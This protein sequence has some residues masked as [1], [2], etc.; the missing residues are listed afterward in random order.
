MSTRPFNIFEFGA[1]SGNDAEY[2][3]K[4]IN[5]KTS[6]FHYTGVEHPDSFPNSKIEI[7]QRLLAQG[8]SESKFEIKPQLFEEFTP[9]QQ[10]ADLIVASRCLSFCESGKFETFMSNI[11]K[12]VNDGGVFLGDIYLS[13]MGHSFTDYTIDRVTSLFDGTAK[14]ATPEKEIP[15]FDGFN[16]KIQLTSNQ[17][18]IH[19]VAQ[20]TGCEGVDFSTATLIDKSNPNVIASQIAYG[21]ISK[22][23]RARADRGDWNKYIDLYKGVNLGRPLITSYFESEEGLSFLDNQIKAIQGEETADF[24]TEVKT[25]QTAETGETE[26]LSPEAMRDLEVFKKCEEYKTPEAHEQDNAPVLTITNTD[27]E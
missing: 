13:A 17:Q 1:S 2:V 15:I 23:E 26:G 11:A 5:S 25:E 8:I 10:K 24:I 3:V 20:K 21:D 14:I 6:N 27:I 7:P 12:S 4:L 22:S 19:F 16:V 18:M 9:L